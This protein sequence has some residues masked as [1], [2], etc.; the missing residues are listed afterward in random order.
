MTG[1]AQMLG[2]ACAQ[3]GGRTQWFATTACRLRL[4]RMRA[5][6]RPVRIMMGHKKVQTM[7]HKVRAPRV[8]PPSDVSTW[9]GP[10][11]KRC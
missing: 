9:C 8:E 7:A 4:A 6:L 11:L 10:S 1:P 2:A 5:E 3:G